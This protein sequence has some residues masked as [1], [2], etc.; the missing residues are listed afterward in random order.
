MLDEATASV[1]Y[2]TD[3]LIQET[4]RREFANCTTITIAHRINTILDSSKILVLDKGE[5]KE[6]DAPQQLLA[7]PN[8]MFYSLARSANEI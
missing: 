6:Y 4:I 5:R 1:D 2:Q 3:V 8:S 7:D